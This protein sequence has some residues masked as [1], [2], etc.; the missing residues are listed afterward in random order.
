MKLLLLM[1]AVVLV[2]C[3]K[4]KQ[5]TELE[6]KLDD[7]VE[8]INVLEEANRPTPHRVDPTTGLPIGGGATPR[9]SVDPTTGLPIGGIRIIDLNQDGIDDT[10][11]LPIRGTPPVQ[12]KKK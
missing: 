11:G 5:L 1:M 7:A 9:P 12:P 10:T 4:S 2:G 8:R 3:G 6:L